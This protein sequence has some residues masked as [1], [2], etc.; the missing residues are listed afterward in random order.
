MAHVL[1]T[2]A[3]GDIGLAVARRL[4]AD[5]HLITGVDLAAPSDADT[6]LDAAA[7]APE[8]RE[9][10]RYCQADVTVR[11]D[12][13][14]AVAGMSRL[15]IAVA[16]AGIVQSARFLDITD[17]VW[18]R[19][20]KTNLTGAFLTTQ[21]AARRM[22]DDGVPGRLLFTGSWVADRA[23][24]EITAYTVTKA[25]LQNLARQAAAELAAAG[26]RVNVIAPGIVDA[27]LART[28]LRAEP[29][30]A[31]RVAGAIPLGTLQRVED[32]VGAFSFACSDDAAY[33][34]GATI[35]VDGGA[36]LGRP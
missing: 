5:G 30:F 9:R 11:A 26:I 10:M 18:D 3:L 35:L 16:N 27:G 17:D 31:E 28:Q 2:G 1:V 32:V 13:E 14:R 33:M 19:H 21:V 4:A 23:W 6:I 36:S 25:A 24:P 29:Q 20:L 15:D 7:G 8:L 22:V 34:T 12:V